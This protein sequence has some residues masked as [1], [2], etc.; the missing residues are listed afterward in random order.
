MQ[1][2]RRKRTNGCSSVTRGHIIATHCVGVDIKLR[3]KKNI[4]LIVKRCNNIHSPL[5]TEDWGGVKISGRD[6]PGVETPA[7][8]GVMSVSLWTCDVLISEADAACHIV[9][10]FKR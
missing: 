2:R 1:I 9:T 6:T 3:S 4:S 5:G 10:S 7:S 8:D